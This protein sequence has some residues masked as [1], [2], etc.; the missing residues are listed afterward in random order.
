M[1]DFINE[2]GKFALQLFFIAV[3]VQI[4]LLVFF[5]Q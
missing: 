2:I 4:L 1:Y 5:G 3:T